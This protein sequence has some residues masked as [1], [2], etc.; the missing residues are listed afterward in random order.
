MNK[1][2]LKTLPPIRRPSSPDPAA[3]CGSF[4][5][6]CLSVIIIAVLDPLPSPWNIPRLTPSRDGERFS[7]PA[8]FTAWL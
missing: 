1:R 6:P 8:W 5:V 3:A 4:A 7:L 2:L